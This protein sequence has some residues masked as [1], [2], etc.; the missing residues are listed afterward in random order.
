MEIPSSTDVSV[1]CLM[2]SLKEYPLVSI[3]VIFIQGLYLSRAAPDLHFFP[4]FIFHM[5]P[6][7]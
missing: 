3:T 5:V 6:N 4:D 1:L 2:G 7:V